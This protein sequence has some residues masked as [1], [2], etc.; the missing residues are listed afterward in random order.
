MDN[1]LLTIPDN[2]VARLRELAKRKLEIAHDPVNL[3][4]KQAWYNYD[5]G[6]NDRVMVIAEFLGI[7]DPNKPIPVENYKCKSTIV[8]QYVKIRR[9]V[10]WIPETNQIWNFLD[11]F[12]RFSI[13]PTFPISTLISWLPAV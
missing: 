7:V 13:W 10:F 4:R 6:E 9:S 2:E 1:Q 12:Q 8:K 3:E 5:S 11:F